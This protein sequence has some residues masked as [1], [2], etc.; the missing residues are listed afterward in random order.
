M[1][2]AVLSG[3]SIEVPAAAPAAVRRRRSGD[4]LGVDLA[5][6]S[7][8]QT[9]AE[10]G[11]PL[12]GASLA[13]F[14][15]AFG[16]DLARLHDAGALGF[17][18][19]PAPQ[20]FFGPLDQP[21]EVPAESVG[22][23]TDYWVEQRLRPL[24]AAAAGDLMGEDEAT[25]ASAIDSIST[26]AFSGI[27]GD[28]EESPARVHGD[29]WAGNLMWA[30][31]GVTLIDPAAHGG[32]RL[33]D[34]ALLDLFGTPFLEEIFSGYEQ[35]HPMPAGWQEDL[36]AHSVFA[37]LAHISLFGHG[38]VGQTVRAARSIIARAEQLDR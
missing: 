6:V 2:E 32:H 3:R 5:P 24:A 36:P 4:E 14:G 26:G 18:W 38:F 15:A 11:R 37:L 29:L 30:P 27:C 21:F 34:L 1:A 7:V 12:D 28:G 22:D 35:I 8:A 17:G 16:R 25:V 13:R 19:S 10:P 31:T 9:M 23:F 20:S 33:E